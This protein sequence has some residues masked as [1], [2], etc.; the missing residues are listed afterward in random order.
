VGKNAKI[1]N[2]SRCLS[3]DRAIIL[4][5][6]IDGHQKLHAAAPYEVQA[7]QVRLIVLVPD[8]DAPCG[9]DIP[10]TV[11]RFAEVEGP[12]QDLYIL[13]DCCPIDPI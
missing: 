12:H 3:T 11:C 8:N 1:D 5:G 13:E 9:L 6:E 7:G 4:T 10:V 2:T